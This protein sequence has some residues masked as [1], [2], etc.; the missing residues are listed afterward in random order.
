MH[1]LTP[2]IIGLLL[3]TSSGCAP[4]QKSDHISPSDEINSAYESRL[5][6]VESNALF[7]YARAQLLLNE[8]NTQAAAE[9]LEKA[10]DAD[11][12]NQ[13]LRFS[14]AELYIQIDQPENAMRVIE[15]ILFQNPD[16]VRA[17][18]TLGNAYFSSQKPEKAIPHYQ[19]VIELDPKREQ[20]RIHLAIA[21]LR[22]GE[23]DKAVD[24]LKVLLKL[25]PNSQPG[26][27]ALARVYR[28]TGLDLLAEEQYLFLVEN[29][30]EMGQAY[31]ELGFLYE[32]R[33]D[34]AEALKVFKKA[35]QN[36]PLDFALRHH[37][38]RIFV[39][40][41]EY[42]KALKELNVIIDLKPDDLDARRKVGLIYMEQA[43][44]SDAAEVFEE[45]LAIQP[46]LD[47]IHYYLGT[48]FEQQENWEMALEAFRQVPDDSKLYE[49][50]LSHITFILMETGRRTE[51][52]AL[53][54][55]HLG[56]GASRPEFY[57]YLA[58]L[59]LE[60][61]QSENALEIIRRGLEQFPEDLELLYQKGMIF[62]RMGDHSQ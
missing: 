6:D 53:L 1:I 39:A 60:D 37:V 8:G 32:E 14:L 52:V 36:R 40:Q 2:L 47:Q 26:R 22:V 42:D 31:L 10:I 58:A 28:D 57:S 30:P 17:H 46:D 11:P 20:T 21:F 48:V 44:W 43:R 54:E 29:F 56:Q 24:T 55:K 34:W 9:A 49:D 19:R 3:L 59:Y 15:D 27:M 38:A 16:S 23:F 13:E 5:D 33:Q 25:N 18:L 62:E 35:Q 7:H 12:K 45:I 41:G 4:A 61:G 51:A 50:S